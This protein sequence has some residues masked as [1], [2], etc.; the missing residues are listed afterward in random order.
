MD[1]ELRARHFLLVGDLRPIRLLS[2]VGSMSARPGEGQDP[3]NDYGSVGSALRLLA[4][5]W[6]FLGGAYLVTLLAGDL[7]LL[8]WPLVAMYLG[9]WW[10]RHQL[11]IWSG[12]LGL[13]VGCA[14]IF[15]LVDVLREHLA[16][17][18]ADTL[19]AGTALVPAIAV[20]VVSARVWSARHNG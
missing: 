13:S 15:P 18:A 12:A 2:S 4:G 7:G 20:M 5:A 17:S 11:P 14:V 3:M 19:A 6:L 9:G 10:W 1:A 8:A 16:K